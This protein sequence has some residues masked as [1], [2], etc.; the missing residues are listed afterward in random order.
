MIGSMW[1]RN[2]LIAISL[3]GAAILFAVAAPRP[4]SKAE[5]GSAWQCSRTALVLTTC[6]QAT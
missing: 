2:L 6:D 4:I 3:A 5:L 1:T